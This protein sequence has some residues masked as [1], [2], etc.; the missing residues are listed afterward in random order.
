MRR[1]HRSGWTFLVAGL[2]TALPIGAAGQ[3]THDHGRQYPLLD[4]M[5][6]EA[7]A[8]VTDAST[9]FP[10]DL[11]RA[12][13]EHATVAG[14]R[15]EDDVRRFDCLADQSALLYAT[16]DLRGARRFMLMAAEHA[17]ATGDVVRAAT[18]FIDAALLAKEAGDGAAALDLARQGR[19]LTYSPLLDAEVR[20]TLAR[21]I[22]GAWR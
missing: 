1:S 7:L 13:K 5:H 8:V 19:L 18:A 11:R 10:D 14:L 16:G 4:R 12:A 9:A 21:R 17:R 6:E 15:A 22:G 3:V 2:A 20:E